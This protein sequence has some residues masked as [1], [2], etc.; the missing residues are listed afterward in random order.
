MKFVQ[1]V[2]AAAL[3]ISLAAVAQKDPPRQKSTP[4][5]YD[6]HIR[7]FLEQHCVACHSGAKPKADLA[8]DLVKDEAALLKERK[9]WQDVLRMLSSGEMPPKEKLRPAAA[10]I[11]MLVASVNGVFD[12]ADRNA[13]P[14][15]VGKP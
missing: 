3:A 7:P 6:D 5:D 13:K 8:L 11:E 12:R 4:S 14:D 10:E 15:R 9:R 2:S 1:M